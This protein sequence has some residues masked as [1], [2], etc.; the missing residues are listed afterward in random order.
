MSLRR[1]FSLP[2]SKLGWKRFLLLLLVFA[3][4]VGLLSA[5]PWR[6]LKPDCLLTV[7]PGESVRAAIESAEGGAV[8]CLARGVW[9][10]NIWIDKSLTI[11]GSGAA[12]TTIGAALALSPVVAVSGRDGD[13]I[14]VKM[15]GLTISGEGGGSA[16]AISGVAEVEI[17]D[18]ALSGRL[19]GIEVA[20]SARLLLAD[21]TVSDHKQRGIVL[22]DS[23][24][25]DI[26]GSRISGNL[27]PGVWISHSAEATFAKCE[28]SR[29]RGH[30]LWL[31]DD[32]R[33]MVDN[34]V[35]SRNEGHGVWLTERSTADLRLSKMSENWDEGVRVDGSAE[36]ELNGCDVLSNWHGVELRDVAR[37]MVVDS[38]ISANRFDGIR[39]QGS[40]ATTVSGSVIS[41]N[42]RGVG[43]SGAADAEISD[44]LIEENLGYGV[45]SWSSGGVGGEA[46]QFRGNG[47][48][49]GGNVSGA[50]RVP[51]QEPREAV[52]SWPDNRYASVQEA[53]DA[54]LPG[55]RLLVKSGSYVAGL[56][57]G[58][59][60]SIEADDGQVV[61]Q[62][63]GDVLP[64]L[65]LVDGAELYISGITLSGGSSGLLVSAAARAVI[66][67][68]NISG[69]TDGINLSFS[70]SAEMSD[71]NITG[72]ERSGI[73]A[74]DAAQARIVRC[75]VSNNDGYGIAAADS[76][77]ITVT[78]CTVSRMGGDG[79][80]VLRGSCQ[81][82]LESNVIFDNSGY[83]VV[84]VEHPCFLGSP[85]LF[86]GL[87][88]G[89]SNVFGS[90][91][92]GDVCP[93]ELEFLSTAEGGEL[94]LRPSSPS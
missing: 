20:D 94:D 73:A 17:R 21:S 40:A 4:V 11:I 26:T 48:D 24:R 53:V 65:S 66:A 12:R 79:G 41:A 91:A 87:I 36:A 76:A 52:V 43:V 13:P 37:A 89:N 90:N 6:V 77:V 74:G 47:M 9:T 85:W 56:T 32:A 81:A 15:Q 2:L 63:R 64:V 30:G 31:R 33:V 72:N 82:V 34:S 1:V 58:K 19:Y 61:L 93:P 49:L 78:G 75:Y 88:S 57:L 59:E 68:C 60:V 10:E 51:L 23:A 42:R 22:A 8:I 55:G 5:R 46:N 16:V 3:A 38:V 62:T 7:Q 45:F 25:A 28:V 50:L 86:Q 71:C 92:R 29:N 67:A 18:C 14:N 70:S 80:I 69:N 35:V 54:L 27:G 44:C 39:I 84:T 83:G